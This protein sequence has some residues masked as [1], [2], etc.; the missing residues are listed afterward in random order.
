MS[1]KVAERVSILLG[2]QIWLPLL[3]IIFIS[4]TGLTAQQIK[5][6]LPPLLL[7]QVIIPL[8]YLHS[9]RRMGWAISWDLPRRKERLRFFILLFFANSISL[10][11]VYLFGSKLLFDLSVLLFLLMSLTVIA[12][13]FSKLSLHVSLNTF[14]ALL[15]NFLFGWSMPFL[16]LAIP[17]I[18]WARLILNKH[19][20]SQLLIPVFIN[21]TLI[22]LFLYYFGYM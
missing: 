9:A 14:G 22:M 8:A 6:L 2:P 20:I 7:F 15:A 1:P 16:Y 12:T 11:L 21:S 19:T 4:R 18:V 3:L 10:V 17:I 5:I 13:Y